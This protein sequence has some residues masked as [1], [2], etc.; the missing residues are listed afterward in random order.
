MSKDF[1]NRTNIIAKQNTI[2]LGEQ[3]L[4]FFMASMGKTHLSLLA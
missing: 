3:M 1:H 2:F 4:E